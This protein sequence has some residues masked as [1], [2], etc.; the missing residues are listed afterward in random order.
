M[1]AYGPCLPL[2]SRPFCSAWRNT[3]PS[4][5]HGASCRGRKVLWKGTGWVFLILT[6]HP[7]LGS[8]CNV[9]FSSLPA[10]V[11]Q[12]RGCATH[13]L[14]W[15]LLVHPP[16][17]TERCTNKSIKIKIHENQHTNVEASWCMSHA[18]TGEGE[19]GDARASAVISGVEVG[20]ITQLGEAEPLNTSPQP[21]SVDSEKSSRYIKIYMYIDIY[22]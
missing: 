16:G 6:P 12:C 1:P 10:P 20:S 9:T 13:T 18:H 19:G 11:R 8:G 14:T 22:I 2:Y 4:Q 21:A 7:G 3:A 5:S 17:Q 15:R